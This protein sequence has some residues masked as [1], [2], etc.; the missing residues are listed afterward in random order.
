MPMRNT[1]GTLDNQNNANETSRLK[2]ERKSHRNNEDKPT[3]N[4]SGLH[5]NRKH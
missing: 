4:L 1:T 5:L 2:A 3:S